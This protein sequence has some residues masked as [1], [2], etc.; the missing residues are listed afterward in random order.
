MAGMASVCVSA[1]DIAAK[2]SGL[3]PPMVSKCVDDTKLVEGEHCQFP[4]PH[5][6]ELRALPW[7]PT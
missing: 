2:M 4:S 6:V 7:E 1:Q 5:V 3:A